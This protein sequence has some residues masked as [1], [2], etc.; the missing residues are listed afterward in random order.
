VKHIE[1][2]E[3]EIEKGLVVTIEGVVVGPFQGKMTNT[4]LRPI[5]F[6]LDSR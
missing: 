4:I 6:Q 2:E 1:I 5:G 3:T